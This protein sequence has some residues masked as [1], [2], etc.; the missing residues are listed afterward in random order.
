MT[1]RQYA[2]C[3]GSAVDFFDHDQINQALMICQGCAVQP[4]CLAEALQL[5]PKS[6]AGGVWGA[7]TKAE[8]DR[9]RPK[10]RRRPVEPCGTYAAYV[11]HKNQKTTICEPCRA[12]NRVQQQEQRERNRRAA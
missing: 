1:W 9:L 10:G 6:D 11:R 3:D 5:T 8:R 4:E 7:H 2:A 12:A